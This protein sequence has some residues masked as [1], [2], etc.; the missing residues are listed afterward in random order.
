MTPSILG[1]VGRT[2]WAAASRWRWAS[3]PGSSPPAS[4]RPSRPPNRPTW[5]CSPSPWPTKSSGRSSGGSPMTRSEDSSRPGWI[6]RRR[7]RARRPLKSAWGSRSKTTSLGCGSAWAPCS[8]RPPDSQPQWAPPCAAS[9]RAAALTRSSSWPGSSRSCWRSVA[10][11]SGWSVARS[12]TSAAVS[13]RE[14]ATLSVPWR[15][16]S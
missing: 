12:A 2:V 11:R 3:P 7:L 10:S 1:C 9:R 14:G 5:W 15:A 6:G 4:A 13:R 8:G 16:G